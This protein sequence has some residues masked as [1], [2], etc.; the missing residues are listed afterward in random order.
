MKNWVFSR[1]ISKMYEKI[2]KL[3]INVKKVKKY[4]E[5]ALHM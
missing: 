3:L 4:L 5:S 1:N 2:F